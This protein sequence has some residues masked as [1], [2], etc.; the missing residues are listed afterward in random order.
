MKMKATNKIETI[1]FIAAALLILLFGYAALSQLV[2]HQ[3]FV[4]Q[5]ELAPVSSMQM[6][7]PV[8][9]WLVPLTMI[10]III[11]L[12]LDRWRTRGLYASFFLLLIFEIYIAG[13]LM[14]GKELP[15]ACGGLHAQLQWRQQL[16]LNAI[17]ILL[18]LFPL[19]YSSTSI[20]FILSNIRRSRLRE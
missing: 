1:S 18:A 12:C 11:M 17:F 2:N 5:M 14:S 4:A 10:V 9:G 15:C 8:L 6:L 7:A 20:R 13:M 3:L 19:I 16:W